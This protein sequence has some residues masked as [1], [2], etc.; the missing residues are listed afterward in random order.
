MDLETAQTLNAFPRPHTD[1]SAKSRSLTG[2][3][4]LSVTS[5][6]SLVDHK[7]VSTQV[8][9]GKSN[10]ENELKR[11]KQL[12]HQWRYMGGGGEW[13]LASIEFLLVSR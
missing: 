8:I 7:A 4:C 1:C 2:L 11:E 9:P 6:Q 12:S 13:G 10:L 3:R 5:E